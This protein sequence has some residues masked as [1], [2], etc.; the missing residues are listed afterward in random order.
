MKP[1]R[2]SVAKRFHRQNLHREPVD[3]LTGDKNTVL[4]FPPLLVPL[5]FEPLTK[6]QILRLYDKPFAFLL[7]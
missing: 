1:K 6:G 3:L 4:R 5:R 2:V 7:N